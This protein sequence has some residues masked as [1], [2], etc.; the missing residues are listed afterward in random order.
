MS[1]ITTEQAIKHLQKV[2]AQDPE[3]HYSW[4]CNIAMAFKDEYRRATERS[5][6]ELD[7]HTIANNAAINFLDILCIDGEKD[8]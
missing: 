3:Y 5:Q 1:N 2:L 7:F 8:E 4:V 6:Y